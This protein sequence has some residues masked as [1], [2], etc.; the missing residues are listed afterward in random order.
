[1]NFCG[2]QPPGWLQF[3]TEAIGDQRKHQRHLEVFHG[4]GTQPL[5]PC[6]GPHAQSWAQPASVINPRLGFER[7]FLASASSSIPAPCRHSS[8]TSFADFG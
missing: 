6:L 7:L 4:I 2:F 5:R 8:Q 1:M 3:V